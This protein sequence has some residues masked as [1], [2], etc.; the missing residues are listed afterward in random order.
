MT[1][2]STFRW[3]IIAPGRIAH[4]FAEALGVV[5]G[6]RLYA[7]ASRNLARG[8]EFAHKHHASGEP[9]RVYGG[10]FEL[11]N[12]PGVDA[13]YIANPHRFHADCIRHCLEAGKAVLCEK[14]LTVNA[15]QA[16]ALFR[17][18]K[19]RNVFLMEALWTR[20]LPAWQQA[21]QWI[22]DGAIGRIHS[23]SADFCF[24]VPFQRDDRLWDIEQAGG[25][26]LDMGVYPLNLSNFIFGR[27]PDRIQ[28]SVL[29][30]E[31]EVDVCTAALLD[32]GAGVSTFTCSFLA[33]RE[34]IFQIEGAGGVIQM[35]KHY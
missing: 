17:L 32:Y 35:E 7:V 19:E 20:F 14:P 31:T 8:E 16:E 3:G 26:L 15:A 13:I 24:R 12:D 22:D 5:E 25:V 34:N 4:N 30:G 27:G 23:I 10:Y 29:K 28:S 21:R 2:G 11:I 1:Y 6:A 33:R 9:P 18:A